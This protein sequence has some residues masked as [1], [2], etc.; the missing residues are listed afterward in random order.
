MLGVSGMISFFAPALFAEWTASQQEK[1]KLVL[2][3]KLFYEKGNCTC[4]LPLIKLKVKFP[5]LYR[6]ATK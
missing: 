4:K 3:D 1:I 5:K 6:Q 2:Q